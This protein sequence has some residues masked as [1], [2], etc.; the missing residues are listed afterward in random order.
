MRHKHAPTRTCKGMEVDEHRL[1]LRST[2]ET[3]IVA[4]K[5]KKGPREQGWAFEESRPRKGKLRARAK[6]H[7][8]PA[9]WWQ[10]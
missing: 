10:P 5:V 8:C 1:I 7:I 9:R 3:R 4:P 2:G 6:V